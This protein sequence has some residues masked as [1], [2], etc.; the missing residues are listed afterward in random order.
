MRT[1]T[2]GR[3]K[4][5]SYNI[6]PVARHTS[7]RNHGAYTPIP[8]IALSC[9]FFSCCPCRLLLTC[10]AFILCPV[11]VVPAVA[12]KEDHGKGGDE[13]SVF[14]PFCVG[15]GCAVQGPWSAIDA[16]KCTTQP[17]GPGL[18]VDHITIPSSAI[19]PTIFLICF[20]MALCNLYWAGAEHSD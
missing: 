14:W 20:S 17:R 16:G 3:E 18:N 19:T 10:A 1:T 2:Q 13:Q 8:Q 12:S 7:P 5:P 15:R 4:Q 6:M 11:R 9:R